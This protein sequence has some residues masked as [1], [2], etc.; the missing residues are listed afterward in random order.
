M[1]VVRTLRGVHQL[2]GKIDALCRT[3]GARQ[4]H[5]VL[6]TQD[7]GLPL[8]KQPR[9]LIDIGDDALADYD[10]LVRFELDLESHCKSSPI[11]GPWLRMRVNVLLRAAA[12]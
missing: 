5:D 10:A 2:D 7:R 9:A 4:R 1:V 12:A 3:I 6:F 8:D 11:H